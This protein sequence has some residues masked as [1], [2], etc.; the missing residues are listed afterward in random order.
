MIGCGYCAFIDGIDVSEDSIPTQNTTAVE[1]V[2]ILN[3]V[4]SPVAETMRSGASDRPMWG[5]VSLAAGVLGYSLMFIRTQTKS[6]A[7]DCILL[8]L[9][10]IAKTL[11]DLRLRPLPE[12]GAWLSLAWKRGLERR[13]GSGPEAPMPSLEAVAIDGSEALSRPKTSPTAMPQPCPPPLKIAWQSPRAG[14]LG[15]MKAGRE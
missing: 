2:S 8:L 15:A 6:A 1:K 5:F 4:V 11:I 9:F 12:L 13:R 10:L 7:S 14:G 3:G